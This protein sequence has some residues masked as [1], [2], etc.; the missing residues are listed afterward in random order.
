MG[1]PRTTLHFSR[2]MSVNYKYR[3]SI[4][5]AL[6]IVFAPG[7]IA[8][9]ELDSSTV[10]SYQMTPDEMQ[11]D[12]LVQ[13]Y[14]DDPDEVALTMPDINPEEGFLEVAD[15]GPALKKAIPE[16]FKAEVDTDTVS[17]ELPPLQTLL[18][19][20]H[21]TKFLKHSFPTAA[22]RVD[23]TR[24]TAAMKHYQTALHQVNLLIGK[25]E[26]LPQNQEASSMTLLEAA[27]KWSR[28]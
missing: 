9:N 21:S 24:M 15:A 26:K 20:E 10:E 27:S 5:A 28:C 22:K 16:S 14:Q 18:Q 13:E 7:L 6:C 23:L 12:A 2:N 19:K 25:L 1:T 3:I 17:V 8:N 11:E 4:L